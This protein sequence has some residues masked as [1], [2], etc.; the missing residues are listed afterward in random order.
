L[1]LENEQT[2]LYRKHSSY[3]E[4]T[5]ITNEEEGRQHGDRGAVVQRFHFSFTFFFFYLMFVY[6]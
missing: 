5:A 2:Y 4:A 6:K 3:N 1:E